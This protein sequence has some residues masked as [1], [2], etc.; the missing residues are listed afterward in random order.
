MGNKKTE[1]YSSALYST[2]SPGWQF[3]NLQIVDIFS[4]DMDSPFLIFVMLPPLIFFFSNAIC[5][6]TSR[7][8]AA[9]TSIL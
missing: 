3:N 5:G 9:S 2:M 4:Q 6:V 8:K 1:G 7:F